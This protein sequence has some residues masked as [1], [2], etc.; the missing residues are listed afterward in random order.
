[1]DENK[2][3]KEIKKMRDAMRV[4]NNVVNEG[5]KVLATEIEEH[6]EVVQEELKELTW[7]RCQNENC[8]LQEWIRYVQSPF[9]Q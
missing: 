8:T 3:L 2:R 4:I 6:L 9:L 1:M 5:D 7:G